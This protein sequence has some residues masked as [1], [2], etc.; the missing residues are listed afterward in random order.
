MCIIIMISNGI[1]IKPF[2]RVSGEYAY[3]LEYNTD[4]ELLLY[5]NKLVLT[6]YGASLLE[7]I[8]GNRYNLTSGNVKIIR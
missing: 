3:E 8:D 5:Y 4:D 7:F 6:L 2:E 1:E